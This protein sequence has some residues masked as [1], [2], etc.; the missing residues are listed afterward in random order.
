MIK[1]LMFISLVVLLFTA[2]AVVS[3]ADDDR[4]SVRSLAA[5]KAGWSS[6]ANQIEEDLYIEE[7]S[8]QVVID[9]YA[10]VF[11]DEKSQA[12][13][14]F[15]KEDGTKLVKDEDSSNP[16]DYKLTATMLSTV[17]L[18]EGDSVVIM[19]YVETDGKY[20]R[21]TVPKNLSTPWLRWYKIR[22][23]HT[24]KDKPNYVRVIAFQK[25]QWQTLKL[26]L[27]L[28]ITD[29]LVVI[30]NENTGFNFKS[31]LKNSRDTI[32]QVENILQ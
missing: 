19:A 7:Y 5:E 30:E 17:K 9:Q 32:K 13:G 29:L 20:D 11:F 27:N 16:Q 31:S 23:P 4:V 10:D 3:M 26:G 12:A 18:A 6:A 25:S 24:G 1:K 15:L 2:G 8:H 21:L 14:V 28:E 22:L